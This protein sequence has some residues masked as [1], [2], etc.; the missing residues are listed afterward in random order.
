MHNTDKTNTICLRKWLHTRHYWRNTDIYCHNFWVTIDGVW[1]S[2]RIYWTLTERNYDSL[3]ELHTPQ[4]TVTTPHI[5]STQPV[6]TSRF[7]VTDPNKVLCFCAHVLTG[8][9][10]THD[11]LLT[12]PTVLLLHFGTDGTENT[13]NMLPSPIVAAQA[14]FFR[15]RCLVTRLHTAVCYTEEPG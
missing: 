1:L 3:T 10:L 2:N 8:W 13:V 9:R 14:C 15:R 11:S 12:A 5:K 7:L 4:I 6:F